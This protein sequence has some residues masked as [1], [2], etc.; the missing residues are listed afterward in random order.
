MTTATQLIKLQQF[1]FSLLISIDVPQIVSVT[2]YFMSFA[3]KKQRQ[4]YQAQML[5][6]IR[7]IK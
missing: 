3:Q 6:I 5:K 7:W 4:I 1:I 2:K